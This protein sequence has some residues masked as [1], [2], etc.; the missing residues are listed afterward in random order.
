MIEFHFK[1]LLDIVIVAFILYQTY[2]LL[3]GTSGM[4]IFA[5]LLTFVIV[6]FLVSHVF[7]M[8]LLGAIINKVANVGIILL[9]I[10]FQDE[11]RTFVSKL[12]SRTATNNIV[13]KI[14][15]II[16]KVDDSEHISGIDQI[17]QAVFNCSKTKTGVLIAIE[18]EAELTHY[19]LS[20]EVIDAEINSRL[21]E[22]IF[23]KNTPLH[24]GAMIISK[25]RIMAAGC[26]LPVSNR[27]DIPKHLGL[28]HRAG[29]GM[30]EKTDALV[31][32]VSEET[33]RVSCMHQGG[34]K[35]NV[36][37]EYL[38]NFLITGSII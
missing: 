18:R 38:T 35:L 19:G 26:I 24:D 17:T 30:T 32:I 36:D 1:D 14:K 7:Q 11:I 20:G 37:K 12:F 22:N 9:V 6:W 3:K 23:F 5:V 27:T 4:N 15:K 13:K 31:I 25:N 33:G 29:L 2:R 28:R 8:E 10:L 34:L 21:I 16:F